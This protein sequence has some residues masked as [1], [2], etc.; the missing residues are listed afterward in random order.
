MSSD[1]GADLGE[2]PL[3]ESFDH[4]P[5]APHAAHRADTVAVV[6]AAYNG[7]RFI[8]RA[9]GSILAQTHSPAEV[10]VVEDGTND[11]TRE[12]ISAEFPTVRYVWQPNGGPPASGASPGSHGFKK[13]I[14]SRNPFG[15]SARVVAQT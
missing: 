2:R 5:A 7:K 8:R 10:I 14:A 4:R 11:G 13:K 12:L 1:G 15:R 9:L 6:R 3:D